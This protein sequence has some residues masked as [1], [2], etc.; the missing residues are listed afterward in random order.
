MVCGGEL[1]RSREEFSDAA[2]AVRARM[3]AAAEL[4]SNAVPGGEAAGH[5][6]KVHVNCAAAVSVRV[7]IVR[8]Q[9]ACTVAEVGRAA[10]RRD[11]A[12]PDA[13]DG[14]RQAGAGDSGRGDRSSSSRIEKGF[15]DRNQSHG[16]LPAVHPI[17]C[18][19]RGRGRSGSGLWVRWPGPWR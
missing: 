7:A 10:V 18:P 3:P 4:Q 8:A 17:S 16:D 9:S 14:V 15:L 1:S 13:Q 12:Q 11:V 5:T 19:R 2:V 6:E